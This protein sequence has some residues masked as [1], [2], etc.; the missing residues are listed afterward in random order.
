MARRAPAEFTSFWFRWPRYDPACLATR[1]STLERVECGLAI[2]PTRA[3]G[4]P[5]VGPFDDAASPLR[6]P[7]VHSQV[8]PQETG[9]GPCA[10]GAH[11]TPEC[12]RKFRAQAGQA[13]AG[14]RPNMAARTPFESAVEWERV[15]RVRPGGTGASR[16]RAGQPATGARLTIG[17]SECWRP[18][19]GNATSAHKYPD[20][21]VKEGI[22][23]DGRV[24]RL[25]P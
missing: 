25:S 9:G 20:A 17:T 8:P 13:A 16:K 12:T 23:P 6:T 19:G 2:T 1:W 18:L 10:S 22:Y 3:G 24:L 11:R 21:D 14:S 7:Q 4:G 15:G 5:S